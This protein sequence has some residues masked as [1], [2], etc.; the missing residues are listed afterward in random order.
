[1]GSA[2]VDK[3]LIS[4]ETLD[5]ANQRLLEVLQTGNLKQASLL[6]VLLFDLRAMTEEKLLTHLVDEHNLGL[7]DLK[8]YDLEKTVAPPL[9]LPL[10]WT[11]WTF[12]F[13]HVEDTWFVATAYYLSQPV[14]KHWTALL[15]ER[16]IWYA[17]SLATITESLD[18]LETAGKGE[19]PAEVPS[20]LPGT[21]TS[22]G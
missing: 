20:L 3:G 21:P 11:T 5:Q 7:I 14:I 13:D 16:I 15:G 10:C 6:Y 22:Q 19:A 2:L 8:G 18:R 9:D 4:V 17:A 12:P 1:M